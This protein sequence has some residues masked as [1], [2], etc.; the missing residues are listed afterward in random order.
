M[1]GTET[2]AEEY[3]G[4]KSLTED[5]KKIVEEEIVEGVNPTYAA[6][7]AKHKP[8]PWGKGHLAL[9]ALSTICFLNSTMSGKTVDL[10]KS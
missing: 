5:G 2:K 8:N 7:M 1:T 4:E 9:Y 10:L 6:I 3:V